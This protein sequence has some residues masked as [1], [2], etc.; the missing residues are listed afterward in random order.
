MKGEAV[1]DFGDGNKGN[2]LKTSHTYTKTGQYIVKL[3][4]SVYAETLASKN[5]NNPV[6]GNALRGKCQDFVV[7][8]TLYIKPSPIISLP[9]SAFVCIVEGKTLQL[10]PKIQYAYNTEYLWKPTNETNPTIVIGATGNYSL[11]ATNRFPNN[12]TCEFSDK[13]EIKEGCEPRLFIPEIFTANKDNI[14]DVLQIPNAHISEFDLRIYNRWGEIVF[15]SKDPEKIWDGSHNG[16]IIAPMMYAFVVSY[17]S[18]YF[19]YRKKITR[20]GGIFL[21]N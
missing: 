7:I 6:L 13:T 20:S 17:K 9:D 11:L 12:T 19:P 16:K 5:I 10:D 3:T 2:G 15:E 8:D 18:L 4:F 1:W 21:M 14:N